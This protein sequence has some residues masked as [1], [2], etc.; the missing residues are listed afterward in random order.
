MV[1]SLTHL[2]ILSTQPRV[3]GLHLLEDFHMARLGNLLSPQES[4]LV[5]CKVLCTHD[6]RGDDA[7]AEADA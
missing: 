6:S 1:L 2:G 4:C 7:D 5:G 3:V